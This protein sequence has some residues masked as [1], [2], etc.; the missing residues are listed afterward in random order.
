MSRHPDRTGRG[1]AAKADEPD[2]RRA[3]Y[4]VFQPQCLEDLQHWVEVDAR[5]ARK[6]V[7]FVRACLRDPFTGLGKPEPLKALGPNVWS[8]R[9][10][11]ADRLVYVVYDDRVDFLQARYH[12]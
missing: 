3:R 8:R 10:T 1:A 5:V 12:Y 4:A 11:Q 9:I 7:E 2:A 6:L